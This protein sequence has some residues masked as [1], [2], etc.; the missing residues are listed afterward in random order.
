MRCDNAKK[1]KK[2]SY[3]S[4]ANFD[5]FLHRIHILHF[6][7]LANLHLY[8][9]SLSHPSHNLVFAKTRDAFWGIFRSR[10]LWSSLHG[11]GWIGAIGQATLD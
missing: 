1:K 4:N 7:Y 5:F 3:P 6:L 9:T 2:S 8:L 11:L 10:R